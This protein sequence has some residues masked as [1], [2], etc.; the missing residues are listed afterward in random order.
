[1]A[2]W[3][4]LM[5]AVV[6]ASPFAVY[7]DDKE[8]KKT[9]D[10]Q[11][12][13]L[14][15]IVNLGRQSAVQDVAIINKVTPQDFKAVNADSVADALTY[16]PGVQVMYGRKLFPYMNIHGFDQNSIATLID[17]V[18]YYET[19]YGGLDINQIGLEGIA[20][21]D[22][23]KGA[24]SVLYG[25]NALGGVINIIT[26]K[27]TETPSFSATAEYGL[28][29]TDDA[30]R[31]G[32]S[33]G[34]RKGI[35]NYWLSY[36]HREW[37]SWDL[38]GDFK[39]RQGRVGK[40]PTIIEDGGERNNSDYKTDNFWAKVGL[41]P[42]DGS[43][44]YVNFHYITTEK[45]YPPNIDSVKV[46]SDFSQF[47]RITAYDD[48]G[49]DLSGEH[50]FAGKFNLQAKLFYHNHLDDYTSYTDETY[51]E[52]I[53]VNGDKAVSTY[54]DYILGGM[55]LGDWGVATWDSLRFSIH[56]RK[57]GHK[58]RDIEH[59]PYAES[60]A[61]TGSLGLENECRLLADKLSVV[62]GVSYDWFDI[63]D[64]QDDPNGDGNIINLDTPDQVHEVDPMVG[65]TFHM[66]DSIELFASVARKTRFPTLSQI[67]TKIPNLDLGAEKAINYTAGVKW[68][69]KDLVKIQVAPFFHDISDFI[70]RSVPPSVNPYGQYENYDK[71]RMLGVEV[72][73]E[74][75]PVKDLLVKIGYMY[76][77][78]SN[79]SPD[80]ISDKVTNVPEYTVDLMLQYVIPV[81]KTRLNW[82]FLFAGKSYYQLPTP[83][84]P[85]DA[86]IVN[87][88][89]KLVNARISQPFL[90]DRLEA[91]LAADNLFDENYEPTS[92]YPAP[93]RRI[94]LG[95]SFKL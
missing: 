22:V 54:K 68:A 57:D 25:P 13:T 61:Y 24:A 43:E 52:I 93:G 49:I 30:Y 56:Y 32:L 16:V 26:K 11:E 89:Y 92:G 91:F 35:F 3:V 45:G 14:G 37:D 2:W 42:S 87:A 69:F 90:K 41:E 18:P 17:G 60:N 86:E 12:Y 21:I 15:E 9:K 75:T 63:A 78:A 81:V 8:T 6:W 76:N 1:M 44:V 33:H 47:D 66:N 65:L 74:I 70:T 62:A 29:G 53:T 55:L 36:S 31:V 23:V 71:I 50:T 20:R 27:P 64:A 4:A 79:E 58:Q 88:S 40:K 5:A 77:D 51:S 34:M 10:Y 28:D 7:A 80:R 73:A 39:P 38:A 85:D 72:D 46:F 95:L 59:L 84:R 19:K 82:T 67:Y 48:W 83:D 94:W